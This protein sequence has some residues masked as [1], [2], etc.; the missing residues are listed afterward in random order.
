M[1]NEKISTMASAGALDGTELVEVV[2]GG[3]NRRT[4]TQDIADLGG[5]GGGGGS[6]QT[7]AVKVMH[8]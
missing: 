1:A 3:A 8:F 7:Y 4:T 2:K 6:R 5:G